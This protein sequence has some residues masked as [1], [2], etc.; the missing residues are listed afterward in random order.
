M[1]NLNVLTYFL[2]PIGFPS[3]Y[4]ISYHPL[5]EKAMLTGNIC[6]II[7]HIHSDILCGKDI[8]H[9][10]AFLYRVKYYEALGAIIKQFNIGVVFNIH[11]EA[12]ILP[13]DVWFQTSDIRLSN[14]SNMLIFALTY[15]ADTCVQSHSKSSQK[16][17]IYRMLLEWGQLVIVWTPIDAGTT[18]EPPF[19]NID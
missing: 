17:C 9:K 11:I 16:R 19:T 10:R 2:N 7:R 1:A 4:E 14:V 18:T 8:N 13:S 5:R 6:G 12:K 15:Y 3:H